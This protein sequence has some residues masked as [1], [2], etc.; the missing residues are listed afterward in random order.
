M[1]KLRRVVNAALGVACL[2]LLF[3][4]A[5]IFGHERILKFRAAMNDGKFDGAIRQYEQGDYK[6][7]QGTVNSIND[8][9]TI[10]NLRNFCFNVDQTRM[11]TDPS[12]TPLG[13]SAYFILSNVH[14]G[15]HVRVYYHD[16]IILRID[17]LE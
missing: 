1:Q 5:N 2:V 6:V 16:P 4:F 15:Q 11:C 9:Q 13:P 14:N 8:S 12:D 10:A 7:I 17:L 3:R